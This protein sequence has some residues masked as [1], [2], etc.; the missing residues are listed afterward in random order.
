[1]KKFRLLCET[2]ASAVQMHHLTVH[3]LPEASNSCS[4]SNKFLQGSIFSCD[5]TFKNT[6]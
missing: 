4:D 1:M 2:A 3:T 6:V 5:Y